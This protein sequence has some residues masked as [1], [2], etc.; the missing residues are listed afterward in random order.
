MKG[1][2]EMY[3]AH[4]VKAVATLMLVPEIY[5]T[6]ALDAMWMLLTLLNVFLLLF[7]SVSSKPVIT[8]RLPDWSPSST[9]PAGPTLEFLSHPSACSSSSKRSRR[10]IHH[11]LG[12]LWSTAG[13]GNAEL[14]GHCLLFC[15]LPECICSWL[16]ITFHGFNYPICF[17][18]A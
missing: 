5:Q 18:G 7:V 1:V 15:C 12:Q 4:W 13:T 17:R 8:S 11:S 9:S 2:Q 3:P 10:S 14:I 16:G 6:I